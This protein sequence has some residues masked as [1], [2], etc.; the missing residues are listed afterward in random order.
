MQPEYQ[1]DGQT[2]AV[3]RWQ[4]L[5]AENH[6]NFE[7]ILLDLPK[8]SPLSRDQPSKMEAIR[9][10]LSLLTIEGQVIELRILGIGGKK[11]TDSG[12]FDDP[13]KLAKAAAAYDGKAE[14]LYFT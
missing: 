2:V 11:R 13:G 7:V 9:R 6:L 14:G 8:S 5:L 1:N 3:P 4:Q 12:Y 10:G